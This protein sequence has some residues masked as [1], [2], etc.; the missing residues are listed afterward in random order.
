MPAFVS[1]LSICIVFVPVFFL[2]G[3]AAYLF[4]PLA[5]SVVFAMLASYFLSRTLVPTMV[6]YLLPKEMPLYQDEHA[7]RRRAD[8]A[9]CT[10]GSTG[11]SSGSGSRYRGLLGWALGHRVPHRSR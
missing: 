11:R 7:H 3:P 9:G 10:S 2:T 1:T 6:L 8:L 5:L 4:A